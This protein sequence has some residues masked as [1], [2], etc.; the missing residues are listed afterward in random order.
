[1]IKI[2]DTENSEFENE[3][4]VFG[5]SPGRSSKF[6]SADYSIT[7]QRCGVFCLICDT[8]VYNTFICRFCL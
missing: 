3:C 6:S 2:T 8:I 4:R 5:G 7:R 1:M